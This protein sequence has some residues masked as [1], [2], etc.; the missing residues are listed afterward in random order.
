ME[1][2][3]FPPPHKNMSLFA[4]AV[5]ELWHLYYIKYYINASKVCMM[6]TKTIEYNKDG[7]TL[8]PK[9]VPKLLVSSKSFLKEEL[10]LIVMKYKLR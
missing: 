7:Y 3:W 6:Q 5:L 1:L 4:F 2:V 10:C 9:F 8:R